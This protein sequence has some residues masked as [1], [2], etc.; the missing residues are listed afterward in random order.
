MRRVGKGGVTKKTTAW[1]LSAALV[2]SAC[3][4]T[5]QAQESTID[6]ETQMSLETEN[7]VSESDEATE[8]DE[9]ADIAE[10]EQSQEV[11]QSENE[12]VQAQTEPI[13]EE[14]ETENEEVSV[15]QQIGNVS[16][17]CPTIGRDGKVTFHYYASE[18]ETITSAYVKGSWDSSWNEYFYMTEDEENSGVWSVTTQLS[19]E[20]SYEYGIVV[21]DNW[22]GDPTNPRTGGNSEI[23]RNPV[24]NSDGSVTIFYYPQSDEE[25]SL[26]Y[27]TDSQTQ[28]SKI[29]MTQDAYHSA[30]L[31]ATV[32]E[33]G[34]YTYC[35][36]V[37]GINTEDINCKEAAFSISKLPQDDAAVKSPVVDGNMVTFS[38]FAPTADSVSLAGQM[39]GWD[40][41]ADAMTYNSDTGFWSITKELAAGKYEYKFVINGGNWVTDPRNAVQSSGN[42]LVEVGEQEV[43]TGEYQYTIY[44]LNDMHQAADD[45]SLWIWTDGVNGVQYYFSEA[46]TLEDGNSWLKSEVALPYESI[47]IIPR[48]YDDWAWQ[49]VDKAFKNEAQEKNVTLYLLNGDA[50]VYTELPEAVEK[51]GRYVIV[52]YD[53]TEKDYEGWNIYSWNTG[54]GSEVS[55]EFEE[56]NG[57]M[58]AKIPVTDTKESISFCMRRSLADDLWAEKDGGDHTVA[59]PLNQTVVKASF[60]QGEGVV[61]SL[62]YNIGYETDV[63]NG[64]ISFYYRDDALFKDY[65]EESLAGKVELILDGDKLAMSYDSE[66]ERYVYTENLS[67]GE[68]YYAYII[69]GELAIDKYNQET[70]V[71][72]GITYSKYIYE[73]FAAELSATVN[74]SVIDYNDNAVITISLGDETDTRIEVTEAYADLSQLGMSDRYII[75]TELMS[76]TIAVKEGTTVGEKEI[77]IEVKDQ[78]GNIYQTTAGVTIKARDKSND[79]DWDEAV[80]YFAVTDRFFD[81]NSSNND[82][83]GTGT[84][85]T[86]L[87]S[88]YHGG[89]FAGLESKLDYLQSLGVNTIWITPVVENIEAV[90]DCDGYAGQTSAGYHGYWAKNFTELNKHLGTEEE[91]A[92]LINAMHSR[93]MKLMVD[94]VLNHAGYGTESLYNDTYAAGKN[95]LRDNTTTVKGDDK[96]DALSGLPDFV[97][98]DSEVRQLLVAWQ[99]SWVSKYNIDYFRVDT[100]K[101]VDDTTWK[102]FKNALTEINPDFKMIGEYAG[103]GYATAAGQLGTG[104]MDSLLDFDFN[105][106]AISFVSGNLANVESF[107][108]SRNKGINN[109][110]TVG[111]F[112]GSHDEDGLMYRLM[113]EKHFDAHKAYSLMKVAAALQITA[114]GQ[115]VI[116]YGEELGQTGA[117]NWPYQ[118]NRYDMDWS[119]A[120]ADNDMLIHYQT[121]LNIRNE[122]SDVF[123]K[124][125]RTTEFLDEENGVLVV[126]RS[127]SQKSLLVGFNINENEAKQISLKVEPNTVYMDLYQNIKYIAD[128]NGQITLELPS[129]SEGGTVI[130]TKNTQQSAENKPSVPENDNSSDIVSNDSSNDQSSVPAATV[131]PAQPTYTKIDGTVVKGWLDVIREALKEALAEIVP[132]SEGI[133]DMNEALIPIVDITIAENILDTIPET[134]VKEMLQSGATYRFHY[135]YQSENNEKEAVIE[136]THEAL[137]EID[138]DLQLYMNTTTD[139]DFG[140]GFKSFILVPKKKVIFETKISVEVNLGKENAGKAAYIFQRN[141]SNQTVELFGCQFIDENGSV[142]VENMDLTDL[143]ILY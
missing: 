15:C 94:V 82:A 29:E 3:P 87:G 127:Y 119:I 30:L 42:S 4:I 68:H 69:D 31:S 141:L 76:G 19:L 41:L 22:V 121:L 142:Q 54:Y 128:S 83:Y 9:T 34:D 131:T 14:L 36:E 84:Y 75:D 86:S 57:K 132:L 10:T 129:A 62:P 117:N 118:E 136:L 113:N 89:D 93:G 138:G 135:Q 109:T 23:L 13:T 95:M 11:T 139:K 24:F 92:S 70:K 81:G 37:N 120:N 91:F 18:G 63:T 78:Y 20:K 45:A 12:A 115:P 96:K 143:I 46:V 44:Y 38:Y 97:T 73:A 50:T 51:E 55:V 112:L 2:F 99:S 137:K 25:V 114:K 85:D 125:S 33:Q 52:E 40:P 48:A 53:R 107:M 32:S 67:A 66:N 103:A 65:N 6:D 105:D 77:P 56:I 126:N 5:T 104:Q 16:K 61:G 90:L 47:Y 49:D 1:I 88:M 58:A 124:G 26:L 106:Q 39:N 60:V 134:V 110:A 35:L 8:N 122:Y 102:A 72:N 79:F 64:K 27:K 71:V 130:L 21:N 111:S 101:H 43:I 80:I 100:V 28:Y 140:Q 108:E 116:Y 123:A 98:E 7:Q 59:I 74:P 17:T 133:A